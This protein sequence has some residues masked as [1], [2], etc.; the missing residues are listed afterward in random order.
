MTPEDKLDE[1]LNRTSVMQSQLAVQGV[2]LEYLGRSDVET[3]QRLTAL[4]R[5]RFTMAGGLVLIA[6]AAP[7]LWHL[8]G[9]R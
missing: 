7:E 9:A 8:V 1:L 6:F 4:E 3:D 5:W 2:H